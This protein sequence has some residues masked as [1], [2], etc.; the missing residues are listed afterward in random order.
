MQQDLIC[1]TLNIQSSPYP[2]HCTAD[3]LC[4]G[5]NID[6][7]SAKHSDTAVVDAVVKYINII[8]ERLEFCRSL[9]L[10]HGVNIITQCSSAKLVTVT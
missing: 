5:S 6:V 8:V 1:L 10:D 2:S 7:T 3:N 9:L 4:A